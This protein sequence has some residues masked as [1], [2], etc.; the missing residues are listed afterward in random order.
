MMMTDKLMHGSKL[1]SRR[2]GAC[3]DAASA[4]SLWPY[5]HADLMATNSSRLGVE[6]PL[7]LGDKH[8]TLSLWCSTKGGGS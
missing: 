8:T 2:V 7:R 1:Q 4:A 6:C 5:L 3:E